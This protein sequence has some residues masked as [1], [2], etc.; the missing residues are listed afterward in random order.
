MAEVKAS[1]K[2][3]KSPRK[4]VK[5]IARVPGAATVCITGDFTQWSE[6]GILLAQGPG[7]EWEVDLLL[8]PGNYQ[9]RLR[10]DGQWRDHAEAA[11]RVP[12][13]FGSENCL[14]SIKE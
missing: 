11:A 10:V 13:P 2:R 12:N 7:G 14:L 8:A 6:E 5:L 4:A 3:S 9:Y 1:Q